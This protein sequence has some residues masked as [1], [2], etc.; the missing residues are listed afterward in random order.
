MDL[1]FST[2]IYGPGGKHEGHEL[3]WKIQDAL[4]YRTD[5]ENEVSKMFIISLGN[6]I[7]LE[8][9][10]QSQ[11]VCT[12]EHGPWS[13]DAFTALCVVDQRISQT[14]EKSRK[15]YL[16]LIGLSEMLQLT[17]VIETS[18]RATLCDPIWTI[19][20]L[21]SA[22][23][24]MKWVNIECNLALFQVQF[25]LHQENW[26]S[27]FWLNSAVLRYFSYEV[28]LVSRRAS[29]HS[30]CSPLC[31]IYH[32]CL[33]PRE[34]SILCIVFTGIMPCE[35]KYA[36]CV[37]CNDNVVFFT[38]NVQNYN[39]LRLSLCCWIKAVLWLNVVKH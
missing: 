13:M 38:G 21:F 17:R 11:A 37:S 23:S 1:V 10:P 28:V 6:W 25:Y 16:N 7:E 32:A 18:R 2:S 8:S 12:L 30:C 34:T 19:F 9:T 31:S 26:M 33:S 36:G 4:T 5:R 3:R 22:W 15:S 24:K 35:Y 39:C 27:P 29:N 20:F 14:L